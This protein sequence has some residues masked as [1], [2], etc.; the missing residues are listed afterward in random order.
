[1][2]TDIYFPFKI[3]IR[4]LYRV[5]LLLAIATAG[6]VFRAKRLENAV[7]ILFN[8]IFRTTSVVLGSWQ[9]S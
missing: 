5:I 2:I 4:V 6:A 8:I 1:M 9:M 7:A 3:L